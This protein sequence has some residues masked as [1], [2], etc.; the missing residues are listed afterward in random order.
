MKMLETGEVMTRQPIILKYLKRGINSLQKELDG[1]I[2]ILSV[3]RALDS[4]VFYSKRKQE[5]KKFVCVLLL[6][7]L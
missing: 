5:K 7:S 1:C 3:M 4:M 2:G 6:T